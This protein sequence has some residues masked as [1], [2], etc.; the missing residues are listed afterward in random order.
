V[1]GVLERVSLLKTGQF[2]KK[3]F[4]HTSVFVFC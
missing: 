4:S 3:N 2:N 1:E